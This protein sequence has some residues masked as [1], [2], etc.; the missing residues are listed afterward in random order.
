MSWRDGSGPS[1]HELMGGFLILQ[2]IRLLTLRRLRSPWRARAGSLQ[3][4]RKALQRASEVAQLQ[5]LEVRVAWSTGV[6][7]RRHPACGALTGRFINAAIG[8]RWSDGHCPYIRAATPARVGCR[9]RMRSPT[10]L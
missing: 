6:M 4:V 10:R 5:G 1:I 9:P 7:M 3:I 2:A 8:A